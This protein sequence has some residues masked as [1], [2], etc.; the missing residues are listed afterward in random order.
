[1]LSIQ[2]AGLSVFSDSPKNLYILGGSEYGIKEK[3]IEILVSKIGAKLEY[4]TVM[5]VVNLMT[6]YQLIPLEPQVYVVRYDKSF[7]SG[8]TEKLA[9]TI[10]K[11]PIV[12]TLVL[13][14]EDS[15]DITKLNKFFPDNTASIDAIDAKHMAKY[16]K[17]DFPELDKKSIE[18]TARNAVNYYQAKSI[19]R[20]LDAIKTK[21]V[22]T[23]NQIVS[24]FDLQA[25]Y[26]NEDIQ[27]AV[28]DR[29]FSAL[30]YIADHYEGDL[31]NI[32]YQ[33]LRT[34]VELDKCFESKYSKSP[35]KECAK[36]WTRVDVY[37]MFNHT[38]EAIKAMRS[39]YTV[40]VSDLITYLG[41][42]LMFKSIPDM[43]L[44]P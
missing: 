8:L 41:S 36:K 3:Y 26:T 43:R 12:G 15:R 16:L 14:Y 21:M 38:Y 19:C 25:T 31:Q 9:R 5:D 7:L 4:D 2:D 40:E 13:I 6:R 37:Y 17:S 10:L 32:L 11:M 30:S 39:G 34:M 28:A 27:M 1:M 24:L 18:Y 44:L 23:E 20:C 22:L 35:L 42:L 33:I 29:N